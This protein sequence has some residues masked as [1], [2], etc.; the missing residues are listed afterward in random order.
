MT[1]S[2]LTDRYLHAVVR[3]VPSSQR[4]ELRQELSERIGDEIDAR[5]EAGADPAEAERLT[6]LELGDPDAQVSAYLDRPQRL[7]GPRHYQTW[8]RVIKTILLSVVPVVAF[9]YPLAQVLADKPI[10]EIASSTFSVLV[11][12]VVHLGFWTTLT[13][14]LLDRSLGDKPLVRWTPESLPEVTEPTRYQLRADAMAN[15][16]FVGIAAALIFGHQLVLPFQDAAGATVPL[17]EPTTW[18]WLKWLLAG[19]LV[20]EVGFWAALLR[21]RRWTYGFVSLRAVLSLVAAA[22]VAVLLFNGRLFNPDFMNRTGWENW[23]E[24]LSRGGTAAIV[25]AFIVVAFA[26]A[27]PIDAWL[28]A[29]R[30]ELAD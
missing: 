9:F 17:F 23:S 29:R 3:G 5:I 30:A 11:T 27:W 26:A 2:T 7:I 25:L 22:P 18:S 24:Q 14:A 6:L 15:F 28:K 8:K 16:T 10:G 1:K 12:V 13:F 4:E 20:L 19:L 21:Q